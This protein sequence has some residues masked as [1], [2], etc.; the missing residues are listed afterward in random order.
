MSLETSPGTRQGGVKRRKRSNYFTRGDLVWARPASLPYW[1]AEVIDTCEDLNRVCARLLNPP[2]VEL[3]AKNLAEEHRIRQRAAAKRQR[4]AGL[5]NSN[6]HTTTE[7]PLA[8]ANVVTA[9]GTRVFFFSKLPTREKFNA[10]VEFRLKRDANDISAYEADFVKAV[11]EAN[12]LMRIVL[13][14]EE[15]QPYAV[16]GVGIVH[17]L[18]R[19]HIAAPRQPNTGT[20]E[21]QTAVIRLRVGFENA[22][23]DLMGFEY[24][25]VLFQFSYA[26]AMSSG[27][28]QSFV[29][30]LQERGRDCNVE[31]SKP[32]DDSKD[33]EQTNQTKSFDLVEPQSC[34]WLRRQGIT[35]SKGFKTMVIPPRDDEYRGVFSTRS[36]HRPNFIGIS[37][38]RLVD[39]HGLNIHIA[40]HDLLHGTPVLDI[41]P[42]LPFCDAHPNARAGWVEE[43]NANGRAKTDHKYDT[44]AARVDRI[45]DTPSA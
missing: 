16:C 30:S 3:L 10:C 42:Y 45:L 39:V 8:E 24:I 5:S 9:S 21:P 33:D 37:C 2:K 44:Q 27:E 32:T 17:S 20:F 18:M 40:D 26:S 1:P 36:P 22:A 19:T 14:P 7:L 11:E 23:R 6:A 13:D 4:N 28:G 41:K 25:W 29:M 34:G 12:R 15:L 38:V 43:V 35:H 31:S